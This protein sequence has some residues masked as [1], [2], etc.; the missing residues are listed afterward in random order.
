MPIILIQ[1]SII[2]S[3]PLHVGWNF[4][5][6]RFLLSHS[7]IHQQ[8]YPSRITVTHLQHQNSRAVSPIH[9]SRLFFSHWV[10]RHWRAAVF[11][12]NEAEMPERKRSRLFASFQQQQDTNRLASAYDRSMELDHHCHLICTR[13]QTV[14][15]HLTDQPSNV[16]LGCHSCWC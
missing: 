7:S 4:K 8:G 13:V 1:A 12:A 10:E 15:I 5:L 6:L 3:K 9:D 16:V 11:V 2:Q 14:K